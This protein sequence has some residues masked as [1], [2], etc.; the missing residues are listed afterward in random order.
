VRWSE[1]W[2][3]IRSGKSLACPWRTSW[4]SG[5]GRDPVLLGQATARAEAE[6]HLDEARV[7]RSLG[8]VWAASGEPAAAAKLWRTALTILQDLGAP[9]ADQVHALLGTIGA[10]P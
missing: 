10:S 6:H 5:A 9:D 4:S 2:R 8:M 3:C 1:G 7:L